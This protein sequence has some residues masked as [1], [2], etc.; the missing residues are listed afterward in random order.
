MTS[1]SALSLK[2]SRQRLQRVVE[3]L[4][5]RQHALE[6]IAVLGDPLLDD[7]HRELR[8]VE[9]HGDLFEGV[10]RTRQRLSDALKALA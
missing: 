1:K 7:L 8:R 10:L 9:Q 5:R 3:S 4:L 2:A 6:Q